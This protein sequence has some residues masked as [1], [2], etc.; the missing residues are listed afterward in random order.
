MSDT[1]TAK[2]TYWYPG[3]SETEHGFPS[4]YAYMSANEVAVQAAIERYETVPDT[5]WPLTVAVRWNLTGWVDV[6]EVDIQT[7]PTFKATKKESH[8]HG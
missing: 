7:H 6:F 2:W 1:Q 4:P 8:V 3:V 5:R